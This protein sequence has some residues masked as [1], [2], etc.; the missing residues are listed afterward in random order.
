MAS[1]V[2]SA[3]AGEH[4]LKLIQAIGV[5]DQCVR[6]LEQ[7]VTNSSAE[8][9]LNPL[10]FVLVHMDCQPQNLIFA[11]KPGPDTE[12]GIPYA[13]LQLSSVLDWEEAAFADPRF[14][15]LLLG[16]KVCANMQQAQAL[17][18]MYQQHSWRSKC[19]H[20]GPIHPWLRLETVHSLST[21]LLQSMN[22][23]GRSPW[24]EKPDLWGK[25]SREFQRLALAGWMFCS[26][27]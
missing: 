24:E 17:W 13:N 9:A 22:Q 20:L 4:D 27:I 26:N 14:E 12:R 10:P 2:E 5:L 7:E 11:K 3:P 8:L 23:G 6:Q 16:R 18:D 1:M 19:I 15:L 21:L 25:I